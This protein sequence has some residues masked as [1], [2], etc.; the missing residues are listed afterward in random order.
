MEIYKIEFD[1]T[2]LE[3]YG[4]SSIHMVG[5]KGVVKITAH[6]PKREGDKI[7]CYVRFEDGHREI[8]FNLNTIFYKD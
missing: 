5:E 3:T 8:I 4:F 2:G 6:F 1:W 7:C